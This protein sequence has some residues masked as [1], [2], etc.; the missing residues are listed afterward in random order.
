MLAQVGL[1][2]L[3]LHGGGTMGRERNGRQF[4]GPILGGVGRRAAGDTGRRAEQAGQAGRHTGRGVRSHKQLQSGCRLFDGDYTTE[5]TRLQAGVRCL[6]CLEPSAIYPLGS[7]NSFR[8]RAPPH[9][10]GRPRILTHARHSARS[11]SPEAAEPCCPCSSSLCVGHHRAVST[12]LLHVLPSVCV[13]HGPAIW[14]SH[15]DDANSG[16]AKVSCVQGRTERQCAKSTL[17]VDHHNT[18]CECVRLVY[19][20][21]TVVTKSPMG[22]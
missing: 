16:P 7:Q 2:R 8:T 1:A 22:A 21:F 4:C 14:A 18:Q 13:L 17:P 12:A 3:Q 9:C 19:Y 15:P 6:P 5:S 10:L 11:D 20:H